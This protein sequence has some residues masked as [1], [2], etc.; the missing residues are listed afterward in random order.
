MFLV[1][2]IKR[3]RNWL[4]SLGDLWRSKN[5]LK[6]SEFSKI[7]IYREKSEKEK[8]EIIINNWIY[9]RMYFLIIL[10]KKKFSLKI[11]K[12]SPEINKEWLFWY[13]L[14]FLQFMYSMLSQFI[15]SNE[16]LSPIIVLKVI[17]VSGSFDQ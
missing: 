7:T 15:M 17:I 1:K 3:L 10:N 12:F 2:S 6:N 8:E 5:R 4:E 16:I 14:N 13:F 9:Q 11:T